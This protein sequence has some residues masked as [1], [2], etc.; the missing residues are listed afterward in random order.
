MN[1]YLFQYCQK[2]VVISND[3]KSVLLC[4]R[5]WEAD[6]D[7]VFSFIGGK[8]ETTDDGIIA[9]LKREKDEEVGENFKVKIFPTLSYNT[10]FRK[11]DGNAMILPHYLALHV[12]W[13]IVLSE[14]YSEYVWVEIEKLA[15]LEPKIPNIPQVIN[16]LLNQNILESD[17]III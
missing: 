9:W 17:F 10:F 16:Q 4:K 7:G 14:E 11:K 13:G 3:S 2:I 12:E 1:Q 6:Y 5:K 8:M 15:D